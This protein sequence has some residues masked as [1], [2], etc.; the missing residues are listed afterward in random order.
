MKKS[1]D[2]KPD[3]P[4]D[5][6]LAVEAALAWLREHSSAGVKDGMA[7][8]GIPSDNALGVPVGTIRK[9]ARELGRSQD[10]S[11]ALWRT[12][13]YEA[14]LLAVF[15]G[16]AAEVSPGQMDA[17][18]RSFENWADCDTACFDLFDHTPHA[19]DK[20]REWS[21]WPG[22]FQKRAAFALLASVALHRKQA[23][24]EAFLESL[25]LIEQAADDDRNFVKKAVN[26]ALRGIGNRNAVLH[27][28]ALELADKLAGSKVPCARWIGSDAARQLRSPATL[29]RVAAKSSQPPVKRSSR[30]S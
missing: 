20:I 12:G 23:G 1:A 21:A 16:V 7:R 27:A 15:T 3:H 13:I 28:A 9:L 6:Q 17:W 22:E 11:L 30:K 4:A 24:D 8:F 10:L 19:F 26:W 14:R 2:G 5:V 18:C 25:K 29:K